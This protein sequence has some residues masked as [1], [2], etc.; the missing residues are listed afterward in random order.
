VPLNFKNFLAADRKRNAARFGLFRP[1]QDLSW[2]DNQPADPL[3][4]ATVNYSAT[5]AFD[6]SLGQILTITLTGDVTSSSINFSGGA[7]VPV[8]LQV[9]LRIVQDATGGR[10]FAL[11]ANLIVDQGFA[12]DLGANRATVLPIEW[13]GVNWRFFGASFSVPTS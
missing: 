8:G 7:N 5:P 1:D 13:N 4:L 3:T 11:P 10:T 2:I 9:F 6:T 12:I